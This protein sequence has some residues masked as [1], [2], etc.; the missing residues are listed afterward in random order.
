MS[1]LAILH[2]TES[3]GGGVLTA[4][5][6]YQAA[7]PEYDHFL[8]YRTR[9]G[10]YVPEGELAAFRET[11]TL[12][13]GF[14][15]PIIDVRNIVGRLSPDVVHAHSS[16]GGF[17]A[18]TAILRRQSRRI[19]YTPHCY[20]FENA[21]LSPLKRILFKSIERALQLNT[22]TTAACSDRELELTRTLHRRARSIHVPN[23]VTKSQRIR[24]PD[25]CG[26]DSE[27]RRTYDLVGMGRV[28]EQKDVAFFAQIVDQAR[29][30]NPHLSAGWIGGG[31]EGLTSMLQKKGIE[32]TGWLSYSE[33]AAVLSRSGVYLHTAAWEGLPM[34][35][36]E[37]NFLGLPILVRK[38][39]AFDNFGDEY[40]SL[41]PAR[42]ARRAVAII[43]CELDRKAC[44]QHW[45]SMLS[46]H[47][48]QNQRDRLIS[49][50]EGL[51]G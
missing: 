9:G 29:K 15:Y 23:C 33:G 7:T 21:H 26:D 8:A 1:K 44:V 42:I 49:V 32:V 25:K 4:I 5:S 39:G 14:V 50:Y 47:S 10:D 2:V 31:D 41:D 35:L 48:E 18:R 38:I 37:A 40:Q 16:F 17:F 46:D 36:L 3:Y 34:S 24:L 27:V 12:S 20:S 22:T 43:D 51:I 6:S 28:S 19:V 11:F 45:N 30:L 13:A